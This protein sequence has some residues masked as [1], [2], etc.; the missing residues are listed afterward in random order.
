MVSK[1]LKI[2]KHAIYAV[3]RGSSVAQYGFGGN[4]QILS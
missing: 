4:G 1:A 3:S 2:K